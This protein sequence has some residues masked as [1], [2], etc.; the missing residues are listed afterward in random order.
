MRVMKRYLDM[1]DMSVLAKM[2]EGNF[3]IALSDYYEVDVTTMQRR[4]RKINE[5]YPGI[6]EKKHY[7]KI[8]VSRW[9]LTKYGIRFAKSFRTAMEKIGYEHKTPTQTI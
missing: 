9:E 1:Y 4:I 6:L 8:P 3:S 2:L 7:K 5:I